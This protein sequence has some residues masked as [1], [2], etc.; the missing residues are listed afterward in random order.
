MNW[1][2]I[3][4]MFLFLH[5]SDDMF[6]IFKSNKLIRS[7]KGESEGF[8]GNMSSFGKIV[9]I[10]GLI[11][12]VLSIM[13][14]CE[15][16]NEDKGKA[17][18]PEV[19]DEMDKAIASC[20]GNLCDMFGCGDDAVR[21]MEFAESGE[22]ITCCQGSCSQSEL[23]SS[24]SSSSELSGFGKPLVYV[25]GDEFKTCTEQGTVCTMDQICSGEQWIKS[26]DVSRC[27]KAQ[28]A[29]RIFSG[30]ISLEGIQGGLINIEKREGTEGYIVWWGLKGEVA[31]GI[32]E[33]VGYPVVGLPYASSCSSSECS[34]SAKDDSGAD[35]QYTILITLDDNGIPQ[36][37][38]SS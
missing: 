10:A 15:A 37:G 4:M 16:M 32:D 22:G 17:E 11:T 2:P 38:A 25:G 26:S 1:D 12:S 31:A 13:G 3:E 14:Q 9:G 8:F 30:K 24:K 19:P 34:F 27:C 29:E 36:V 6:K 20:P 33:A 5:P 35:A 21:I 23:S 7:K 18:V 28:C